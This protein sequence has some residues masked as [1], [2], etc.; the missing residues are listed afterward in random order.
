MPVAGAARADPLTQFQCGAQ[1]EEKDYGRANAAATEALQIGEG[2]EPDEAEGESHPCRSS[3]K[4][5][6][7]YSIVGTSPSFNGTAGCQPSFS[8]ASDI[9]GWR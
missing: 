9:S 1:E 3:D 5:R 4:S 2:S 6:S 8:V 7:K